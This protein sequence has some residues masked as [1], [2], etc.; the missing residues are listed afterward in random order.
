MDALTT[1]YIKKL[2]SLQAR[3]GMRFNSFVV[4]VYWD[5]YY[6]CVIRCSYSDD[7]GRYMAD[8]TQCITERDYERVFRQLESDVKIKTEREI[9]D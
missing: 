8:F 7:H 5:S 9:Y 1:E 2:Q 6:E 3:Y 4:G